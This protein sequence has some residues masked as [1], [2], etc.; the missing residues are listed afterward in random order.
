MR[1]GLL[2]VPLSSGFFASLGLYDAI[3]KFRQMIPLRRESWRSHAVRQP[4]H[5]QIRKD[6]T[7]MNIVSRWQPAEK[8]CRIASQASLVPGPSVALPS[9][10]W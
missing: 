7:H 8:I 3:V 5:R 1:L 2:T 10:A 9:T 6:I 4:N